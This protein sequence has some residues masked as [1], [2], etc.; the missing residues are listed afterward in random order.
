MSLRR[1]SVYAR[2]RGRERERER[3]LHTR[4]YNTRLTV[5]RDELEKGVHL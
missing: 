1:V 3:E 4:K 5:E 2:E